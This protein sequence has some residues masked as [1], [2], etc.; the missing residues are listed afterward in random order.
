[1]RDVIAMVLAGGM[2]ERLRP[3][4]DVRAKPAVPFGGVYR[5][6]D[7]CLSNC[8]NS[9]IRRVHVL[10]QYKSHSLSNHLKSGW[11]FLSRRVGEFVDEIP[12]QM[13]MGR[14]WYRGTADAIRQN[15]SFLDQVK[16]R[17]VLVV[18][19]DHVCK[20][21][22][23]PL[24]AFHEQRGACM[25]VAATVLDAAHA[26]GDYGV[27]TTDDDGRVR[28]FAEKPQAPATLPGT[29]RCLV[30]MGI[31]LFDYSTLRDCLRR[32]DHHDFGRDVLPA[33]LA[34]GERVAAFD[35]PRLNAIKEYEFVL[36][37]GQRRKRLS[38]RANDSD[39]WRDVG[40]LEAFWR[41]NLDLVA[42]TPRFSLYG[43]N[44]P[45][46]NVPEHFPP[47][48]FVHEAPGRTG[49]AVNS[50]VCDGVIISG[51]LVRNSVLSPGLFV[52]SHSLIE[53]SVLF[54]GSME[55]GTVAE[56]SIGRGCRLRNAIV[57]K[58]VTLRE[59]TTIGHDREA[60]E[61]RGLTTRPLR[62]SDGYIVVVPKGTDL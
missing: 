54:G 9:G 39:Y 7:F 5:I 4:T 47:A 48:K 62:D 6:I 51:A 43:E 16:P 57:D 24:V 34:S 27:L 2:G 29:D 13:Q 12:A 36:E 45:L 32:E 15:V 44:W 14:D 18:P 56:T 19:G 21:D 31:Y 37:D 17:H 8:M 53:S 35:F 26:R 61:A 40:T 30:S 1:M 55:G 28:S 3:L 38:A 59:G 60:D 42:P 20:M 10:T 49:M 52:H 46:F 22:Y 58:S 41:A 23:R 25:T 50:I 33:L 11:N